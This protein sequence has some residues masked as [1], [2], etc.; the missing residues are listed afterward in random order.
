MEGNYRFSLSEVVF[1][2]FVIV[3][4]CCCCWSCWFYWFCYCF[5][6]RT[7]IFFN[8][9]PLSRFSSYFSDLFVILI[10]VVTANVIAVV[11]VMYSE[12]TNLL[13]I[14][15]PS[16]SQKQPLRHPERSRPIKQNVIGYVWGSEARNP[17]SES[18]GSGNDSCSPVFFISFFSSVILFRLAIRTSRS[19]ELTKREWKYNLRLLACFHFSPFF[20]LLSFILWKLKNKPPKT[21]FGSSRNL[22][23]SWHFPRACLF[24]IYALPQSAQTERSYE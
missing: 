19:H 2:A 9:L 7:D 21:N 15:F 13:M 23:R 20:F 17:A 12:E 11:V 3:F 8:N 22:K 14:F 5:A 1:V 10:I 24:Y 18:V 16:Q 4:C 6:I